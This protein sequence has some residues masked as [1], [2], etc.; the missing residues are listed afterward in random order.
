MTPESVSALFDLEGRTAI[1]TGASRGIGRALATGLA[2][3]G[4]NVVVTARSA[5]SLQAVSASVE[6]LGRRCDV[7][8]LDVTDMA[9]IE[10]FF[11]AL[12]HDG[13]KA[14]ILVNNAGIEQVCPST[15]VDE[16]LWDRISNTNL[17]GAFFVAQHFARVLFE[18][19]CQGS[20]INM[21]SLTSAVGVPGATAYTSSKSGILGMTRALSTE[22]SPRGVRVNAMGPGYFRTALTEQFY[23]DDRWQEAML[24]KIPMQRFGDLNDLV[25]LC[26]FLAGNASAYVSGQIFYVDGGYL[27]AI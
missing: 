23:Q 14:D 27:A 3:A 22:W 21:G 11:A 17:K 8:A 9:S 15:D 5:S 20:I 1:I 19:R 18:A 24:K 25:G 4:A 6:A 16:P 7:H 26:V 2:A 12:E 10:Q 13:I